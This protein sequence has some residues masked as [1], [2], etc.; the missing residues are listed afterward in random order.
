MKEGV[1]LCNPNK[2]IPSNDINEPNRSSRLRIEYSLPR[3]GEGPP[4]A[5]VRVG[6][7][8]MGSIRGCSFAPDK[9]I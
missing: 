1:G 7:R 2:P 8:G 4:Q 5:A 6:K 3:G 9:W